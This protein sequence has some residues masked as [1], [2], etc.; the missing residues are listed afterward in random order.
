MDVSG[1]SMILE[2]YP[3][4]TQKLSHVHRWVGNCETGPPD[5]VAFFAWV[6]KLIP[7]PRFSKFE[8]VLGI[9]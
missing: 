4:F 3:Y 2:V 5:K 7:V 1:I 8:D 6:L 9:I